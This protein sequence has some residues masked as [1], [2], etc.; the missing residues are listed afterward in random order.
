[1]KQYLIRLVCTFIVATSMSALTP[2]TAQYVRTQMYNYPLTISPILTDSNYT[3]RP[4]WLNLQCWTGNPAMQPV[5][6]YRAPWVSAPYPSQLKARFKPY[7][8]A[9]EELMLSEEYSK[10]ATRWMQVGL[11]ASMANNSAGFFYDS[12]QFQFGSRSNNLS[13]L[14]LGA[15]VPGM[16]Y[17]AKSN[18]YRDRAVKYLHL[19]E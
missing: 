8:R 11:G 6:R 19:G 10:R 2:L 18:K 16:I 14:S 9:Y 7:P 17:G 1:M 3:I 12:G 4:Q 13:W 5:D 15:L